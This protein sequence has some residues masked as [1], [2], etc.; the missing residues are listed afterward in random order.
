VTVAQR[1]EALV[2]ERAQGHFARRAIAAA[3]A[4]DLRQRQS[5]AGH[6][7]ELRT[8]SSSERSVRHG[9]SL[10]ISSAFTVTLRC[11]L[12][13]TFLGCRQKFLNAY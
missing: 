9:E 1:E 3:Q 4:V 13:N 7:E 6:F 8:N 12:F 2:D 5:K 10:S 11:D